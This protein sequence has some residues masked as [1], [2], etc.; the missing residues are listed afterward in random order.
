MSRMKY[1][2]R[3]RDS[4]RMG[5]R[6]EKDRQRGPS[7]W[8]PDPI[9]I[10]PYFMVQYGNKLALSAVGFLVSTGILSAFIDEDGIVMFSH[11]KDDVAVPIMLTLAFALWVGSVTLPVRW[12]REHRRY[13]ALEAEINGELIDVET[14]D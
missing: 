3:V 10:S 11:S 14:F 5:R 12:W 8:V 9:V 1:M 6:Y 4:Q 7:D 13:R 2:T